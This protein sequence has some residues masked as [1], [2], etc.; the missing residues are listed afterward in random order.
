MVVKIQNVNVILEGLKKVTGVVAK[1]SAIPI[2]QG[3]LVEIKKDHLLLTGSDGKT[4]VQTVCKPIESD[5]EKSFVVSA[6]IFNDLLKKIPKQETTLEIKENSIVIS[7]GKSTFTLNTFDASDFLP[8]LSSI[9][10]DK[11]LSLSGAEFA[12]ALSSVVYAVSDLESRPILTGVLIQSEG[13]NITLTATDSHRLARCIYTVTTVE[14]IPDIVIPG[15]AVKEMIRLMEGEEEVVIEV[16][17][18][19]LQ[20]KTEQLIFATSLLD[21]TYPNVRNIIPVDFKYKCSVNKS[22]FEQV[23]DRNNIIAKD[24]KNHITKIEMKNDS[25]P[26][27]KISSKNESGQAEEELFTK[28][29]IGEDLEFNINNKYLLDAVK[30]FIGKEVEIKANGALQPI[31]LKPKETDN[32]FCLILPIRVY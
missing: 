19:Q 32:L 17:E 8:R 25:V 23:L 5:I 31:I 1:S 7:S 22:E 11:K 30:T 24:Q 21:G 9:K 4:S 28:D 2:L 15:N 6:K 13:E 3:V 12:K 26:A 27:L 16:S 20:L 10:L 14:E 18:N 29:Y